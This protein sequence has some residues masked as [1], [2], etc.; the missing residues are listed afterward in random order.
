MMKLKKNRRLKM[1]NQEYFFLL[2]EEF[3]Q[4]EGKYD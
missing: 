3:K 4:S 2:E 1:T